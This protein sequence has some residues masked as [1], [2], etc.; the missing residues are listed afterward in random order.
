MQFIKNGK[1]GEMLITHVQEKNKQ[2]AEKNPTQIIDCFATLW[3]M[4]KMF[5]ETP[6]LLLCKL[7]FTGHWNCKNA[8]KHLKPSRC[9]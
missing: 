6:F 5:T 4:R 9:I 2:P 7:D 8:N 3:T 1:N